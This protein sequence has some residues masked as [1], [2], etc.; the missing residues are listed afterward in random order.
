MIQLL[1]RFWKWW[2][3]S[4]AYE[5]WKE[6]WDKLQA[7]TRS[8]GRS[9]RYWEIWYKEVCPA[10]KVLSEGTPKAFRHPSTENILEDMGKPVSER[11]YF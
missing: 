7:E 9:L 10:Y 8:N 3:I 2:N 11:K 1:K 4:S 5:V 6:A